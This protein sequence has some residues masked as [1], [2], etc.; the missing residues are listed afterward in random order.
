MKD[1]FF[2]FIDFKGP[3]PTN[4]RNAYMLTIVDEYSRFPFIFPCPDMKTT[5]V[6]TC[7]DK[8]FSFCGFPSYIHSDRGASFVSQ[9]L[10]QYLL[11]KGIASSHSTPYHPE[12]NSQVERY[13]GI[14]WKTIRLLLKSRNLPEK[15]WEEVLSQALHSIRSLLCTATNSTPHERFFKF[16]SPP[17]SDSII[18][19][20]KML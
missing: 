14:I 20:G 13:N 4:T 17:P 3:L 1:C 16:H 5:T 2:H 6:M 19:K 9:E 7:L 8:L 15:C 18:Q 12:G 11:S 10:K